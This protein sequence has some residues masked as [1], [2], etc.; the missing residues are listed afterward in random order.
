MNVLHVVYAVL[1]GIGAYL[2][3]S[4]PFALVI[5]KGFFGIDVR[6]HGSGN[7]GTTNVFRVLGKKAGILVFIGDMAK[8]FVPA[9]LAAHLHLFAPWLVI[10][11]AMLPIIG[12]MYSIFLRGGGG[13]GVA[14]GAAVVLALMWQVYV[15]LLVV[16][17][18]VLLASRVVCLASICSTVCFAPFT[19]VFAEPWAYRVAAIIVTLG[20]LWAH[21]SNMRRLFLRCEERVTFPWNRRAAGGRNDE[22][23]DERKDERE[24][25]GDVTGRTA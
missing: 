23:K 1:F 6:D 7:V 2:L 21:R 15:I 12:H 20:V 9:F 13:K 5:G 4:I 25:R 19:F 18:V 10:I 17:I 24:G 22:R 11:L 8:G 3:G 16:W 14:T